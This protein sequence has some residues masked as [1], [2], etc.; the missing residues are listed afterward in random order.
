MQ[1]RGRPP[2]TGVVYN[3]TLSRPGAALTLA[4]VRVGGKARVAGGVDRGN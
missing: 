3:T 1:F 2:V 4:F